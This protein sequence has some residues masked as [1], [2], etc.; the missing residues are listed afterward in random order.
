MAERVEPMLA[1]NPDTVI[2]MRKGWFASCGHSHGRSSLAVRVAARVSRAAL[3]ICLPLLILL[4]IATTG[5]AHA[6]LMK[7]SL[8]P[9]SVVSQAT[10]DVSLTFNSRIDAPRSR[11]TLI[12]PDSVDQKVGIDG[13]KSPDTLTVQLNHLKSGSYR[14]RW[15]V[16]AVDGH[17]TRGEIPFRVQIPTT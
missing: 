4:A 7:S 16:L 1:K 2:G 14:L 10:I 6:I 5:H 12:G 15:Q 11:V 8:T 17:I 13:Q 9:N 3:L